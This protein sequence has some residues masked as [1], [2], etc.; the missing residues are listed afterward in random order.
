MMPQIPQKINFQ[1]RKKKMKKV[2]IKIYRV[3]IEKQQKQIKKERGTN[4]KQTDRQ[5]DRQTDKLNLA[6]VIG[7]LILLTFSHGLCK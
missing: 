6:D 1:E 4:N 7:L 5:T 2:E 3:K